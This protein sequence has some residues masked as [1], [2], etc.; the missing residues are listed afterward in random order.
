MTVAKVDIRGLEKAAVLQALHTA[1]CGSSY[2]WL[3]IASWPM[4]LET[5]RR[6]CGSPT[7]CDKFAYE[8]LKVNIRGDELD[9]WF[10]DVEFG[11]DLGRVTIE[12]LRDAATGP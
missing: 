3:R 4:S 1:A 12:V 11:Y 9:T 6:L 8:V 7:E 2:G 5:F 10:Y